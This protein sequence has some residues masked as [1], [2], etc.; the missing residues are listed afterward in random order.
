ME[1]MRP[2]VVTVVQQLPVNTPFLWYKFEGLRAR[3][4][5]IEM[6]AIDRVPGHNGTL[7]T[8]DQQARRHVRHAW[9]RRSKALAGALLPFALIDCLL[10]NPSGTWRYVRGALQRFG[11]AAPRF[12]YLDA[13]I[14]AARPDLVHFEFGP[15]AVTRLHLRDWLGCAMTVSF[16]GYDLNHTG[17]DDPAYYD[18]VWRDADGLHLLGHDLWRRA[19]SRG[20]PPGKFHVLIPPA[21][22]TAAFAPRGERDHGSVGTPDRPLRLV[23]VG[24]LVWKK[25]YEYALLAVRQLEDRGIA[26][27]Y[28]LIGD[29]DRLEALAFAR[30]QLGLERSVTLVGA[31]PPPRVSDHLA[32]ADV[33]VHPAVSE[34]F[35]NAVIEAQAAALPVVTS[36]AGGLGENV[37]DGETGFVV[38][39]RNPEQLAAKLAQLAADGE[40]RRRMGRAARQ[41]AVTHFSLDAQMT[42]FE[43]FYQAAAE[44]RR[45]DAR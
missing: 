43:G 39:R 42:A 3:G 7:L 27:E 33:F 13:A 29:G 28:R 23:S 14:I 4:W 11:A 18:G 20:C 16:R 25:G 1:Q 38:P 19:R 15:L 41:R 21:V 35:C 32:W 40:V 37:A 26:C 30:Q 44:H 34:G 2:R 6:V 36:D 5:P 22:D 10:K 9:P 8:L 17:L 45:V 31:C 24:R 12:F